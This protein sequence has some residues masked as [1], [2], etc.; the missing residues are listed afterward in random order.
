MSFII[1]VVFVVCFILLCL[2]FVLEIAAIL[3]GA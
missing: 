2:A 1:K 3:M